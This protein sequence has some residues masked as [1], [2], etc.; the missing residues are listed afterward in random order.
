[1]VLA[2]LCRS[3]FSLVVGKCFL[4][5][6]CIFCIIYGL[7][8]PNL[9]P[10]NLSFFQIVC[11]ATRKVILECSL[12]GQFYTNLSKIT[13]LTYPLLLIYRGMGDLRKSHSRSG[14][15]E[16]MSWIFNDMINPFSDLLW[17]IGLQIKKLTF[18]SSG[19]QLPMTIF[20]WT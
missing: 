10:T 20:I 17:P 4:F 3:V 16:P 19:F 13:S 14:E 6:R 7:C 8:L 18:K 2:G 12:Q 11:T 1:M 9:V 15:N 5:V